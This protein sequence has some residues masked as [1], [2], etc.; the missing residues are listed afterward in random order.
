MSGR[1]DA[2][3]CAAYRLMHFRRVTTISIAEAICSRRTYVS[4]V[5]VGYER[6]GPTWRRIR[7]HLLAHGLAEAVALLE[8]V[9]EREPQRTA[10]RSTAKAGDGGSEIGERAKTAGVLAKPVNTARPLVRAFNR[11]KKRQAL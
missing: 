9:P 11:W 3:L 8:A 1:R 5:L 7:A 2:N 6:R 4:R 10:L